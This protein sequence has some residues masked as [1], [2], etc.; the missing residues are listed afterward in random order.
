MSLGSHV[1]FSYPFSHIA[2][3]IEAAAKTTDNNVK[4]ELRDFDSNLL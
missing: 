2:Y 3:R 4:K 1:H